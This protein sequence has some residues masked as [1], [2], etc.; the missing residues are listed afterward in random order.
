MD[1]QDAADLLEI[2]L[3][4]LK[5]TPGCELPLDQPECPP[6]TAALCDAWFRQRL[7]DL[8]FGAVPP[9]ALRPWVT[10]RIG[11]AY[12]LARIHASDGET[13]VAMSPREFLDRLLIEEWHGVLRFRWAELVRELDQQSR[14]E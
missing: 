2:W 4:V 11:Q 14:G 12:S 10:A 6:S 8:D 3:E 1:W 7:H 13:P 9:T 5:R